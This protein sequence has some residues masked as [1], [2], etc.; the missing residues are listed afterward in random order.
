MSRPELHTAERPKERHCFGDYVL[1]LEGGF[2]RRRGEEVSLRPKSFEV[3]ACLVKHHRRLVTKAAL[4][5]T[6]WPDTAVTDS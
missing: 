3:L 5:E 6:I 2:L 1:D 4:M